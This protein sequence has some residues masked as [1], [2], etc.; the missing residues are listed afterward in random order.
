MIMS[1]GTSED[2][3]SKDFSS[4]GSVR[5]LA[6]GKEV[7]GKASLTPWWD[8]TSTPHFTSFHLIK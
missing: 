2:P 7:V 4:A 1:L 3:G 8:G 5:N 6:Q